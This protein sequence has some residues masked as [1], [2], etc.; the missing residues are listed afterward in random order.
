[1]QSSWKFCC[2]SLNLSYFDSNEDVNADKNEFLSFSTS[3]DLRIDLCTSKSCLGD[4]GYP[5][6]FRNLGSLTLGVNVS[7][8]YTLFLVGLR[9][10]SYG[11]VKKREASSKLFRDSVLCLMLSNKGYALWGVRNDVTFDGG[12]SDSPLLEPVRLEAPIFLMCSKVPSLL[13]LWL[14]TCL[15][16]SFECFTPWA[17]NLVNLDFDS[18][19]LSNSLWRSPTK[20]ILSVYFGN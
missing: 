16:I 10:L 3:C 2:A 14:N 9:L 20:R 13:N 8:N 5:F 4:A 1:M 18:L 17:V 11:C 12:M 6:C 7:L 19:I 15:D